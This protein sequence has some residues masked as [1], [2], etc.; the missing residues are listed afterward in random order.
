MRAHTAMGSHVPVSGSLLALARA[1]PRI[2]TD[3]LRV[4]SAHLPSVVEERCHVC[5]LG[6]VFSDRRGRRHYDP[7]IVCTESVVL[8][9]ECFESFYE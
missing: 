6:V 7:H 1:R 4:V 9:P 5:G 8:C 2:P 3:C